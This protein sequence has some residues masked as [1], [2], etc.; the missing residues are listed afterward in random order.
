M[1]LVRSLSMPLIAI[2]ALTACAST[3]VQKETAALV[4]LQAEMEFSK[5]DAERTIKVTIIHDD[6]NGPSLVHPKIFIDGKYV[7]SISQRQKIE[8]FTKPGVHMLGW[9]AITKGNYHEQEFTISDNLKSIF[10]LQ[11]PTGD[12][13]RFVR[14]KS[15]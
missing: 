9:S 10:H 3:P 4:P 12:M 8:F 15:S 1:L 11:N 6:V 2:L 13:M 7:G 5:P 14:E